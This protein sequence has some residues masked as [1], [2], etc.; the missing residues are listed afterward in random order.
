V[1]AGD[2][3][4]QI[5]MQHWLAIPGQGI[6]AWA[7]IRRSRTL[8]FEPQFATYD[9]EYAYLPQRTPYP[10]SEYS[11]NNKE[12]NKA[13]QWLGGTDDLWTKLWFALPNKK[14]PYLPY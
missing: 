13:V 10:G 5:I 12:V 6:D 7:L 2:Y 4:R 11:T 3:Y 9:G 14:N 1:P 8:E